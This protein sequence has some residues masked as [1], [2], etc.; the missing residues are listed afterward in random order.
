M[1]NTTYLL[2]KELNTSVELVIPEDI[3][4]KLSIAKLRFLICPV[5]VQCHDKKIPDRSNSKFTPFTEFVPSGMTL[6]L[7][8]Y[9][10]LL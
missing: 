2:F 1:S 6:K 9:N 7:N 10:T 3:K 5:S 8:N 4:I